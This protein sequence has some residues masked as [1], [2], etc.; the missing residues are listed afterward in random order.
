MDGRTDGHGTAG[1]ADCNS[2]R[3]RAYKRRQKFNSEM[4]TFVETSASEASRIYF[5]SYC[6]FYEMIFFFF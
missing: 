4:A 6:R 1:C 5:C 3:G 2:N